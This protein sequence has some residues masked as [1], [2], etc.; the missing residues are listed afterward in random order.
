MLLEKILTD[1]KHMV[2]YTIERRAIVIQSAS[3]L[4]NTSLQEIMHILHIVA[5]IQILAITMLQDVEP[6]ILGNQSCDVI[7]LAVKV[8]S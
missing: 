6:W 4:L 8:L 2:N 5:V 1:L 7:V 3:N